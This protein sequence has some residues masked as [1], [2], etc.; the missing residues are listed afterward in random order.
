AREVGGIYLDRNDIP[1]AWGFFRLI[2]EPGPVK[3]AL[4]KYAPGPDDD[5]Y[6]V[7]DIAWH[8]QL[9]PEKGFDLILDRHGVCS[10]ITTVGGA[11]L[12][13][14]PDLRTYCVRRLVRAVHDQLS[15]RARADLAAR[16]IPVPDGASISRMI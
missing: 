11:D 2:G 3:E 13:S 15:D 4:A 1:R 7:V 12:S 5:T 16:D 10:A 6:P 8:Q 14:H 9:H